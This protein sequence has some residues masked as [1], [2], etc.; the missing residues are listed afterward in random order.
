MRAKEPTHNTICHGRCRRWVR[1][2]AQVLLEMYDVGHVFLFDL[3]ASMQLAAAPPPS[4]LLMLQ[5]GFQKN[6]KLIPPKSLYRRPPR[7][8]I[9]FL[10]EFQS[11][12]GHRGSAS[13][14]D[15]YDF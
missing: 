10:I 4:I 6:M 1:K 9:L 11:R 13:G 7:D 12:N 15:V 3:V 14:N 8:V 5:S 2:Q